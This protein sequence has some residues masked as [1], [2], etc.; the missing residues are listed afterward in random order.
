MNDQQSTN[1]FIF[2]GAWVAGI[3]VVTVGLGIAYFELPMT[4]AWF[5]GTS[6][7]GLALMGLDK[8]VARSSSPRTESSRSS[9][10]RSGSLRAPEAII[11]LIALLGG[12]VG[13]FLGV[14]LFKHKTKKAS[15]Q[16]VLL[17]IV[18]VQLFLIKQVAQYL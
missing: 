8:S 16:F 2:F 5:I 18:V 17:L 3:V 12:S 6:I 9:S 1:P 15:F 14:H 4:E 7:A 11:Y 10:P 13:V